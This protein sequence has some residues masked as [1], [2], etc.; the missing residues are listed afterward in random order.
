MGDRRISAQR[1]EATSL[2]LIVDDDP[3]KNLAKSRAGG[4]LAVDRR[5]GTA[6]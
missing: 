2:V 5:R 6:S 3:E 1:T 4:Q